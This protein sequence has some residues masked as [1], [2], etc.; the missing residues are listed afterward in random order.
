MQM[1]HTLLHLQIYSLDNYIN[2]SISIISKFDFPFI[3]SLAVGEQ[4]AEGALCVKEF[5][6]KRDDC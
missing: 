1:G 2:I 3:F 4:C 5:Q 6:G